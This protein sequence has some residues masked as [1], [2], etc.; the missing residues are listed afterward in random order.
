MIAVYRG[1]C[2]QCKRRGL[3]TVG[4]YKWDG[5]TEDGRGSGGVV[6]FHLCQHCGGRFKKSEGD[7]VTPTDDEWTRH[8]PNQAAAGNAPIAPRVH[9]G[10]D[11]RRV[12]E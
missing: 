4:S 10:H 7:W 2:R 11:Y 9:S 3:R 1:R 6:F 8:V 5:V 12:T